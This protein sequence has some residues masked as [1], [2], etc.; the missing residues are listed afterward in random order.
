MVEK[1]HSS[2]PSV[3][4]L[5]TFSLRTLIQ[6]RAFLGEF[7]ARGGL[8]ALQDVIRRSSG[9][10]L[11]YSL[12]S[13]QN[14]LELDEDGGSTG[15]E[16]S[17]VARIV[18]I[19]GTQSSS[20]SFPSFAHSRFSPSTATEPLINISR[21]ATAILRRLASQPPSGSAPYNAESPN[22]STPRSGANDG[23][24]SG[25]AAVY[26]EISQ[27]PR[28]LTVVVERLSSGDVPVT[29]SSL[30]LLN[31][32]LRGATGLGDF[33]LSEE[34]DALDA[35]KTVG[36]RPLSLPML[37]LIT[38]MPFSPSQKLLAGTTGADL[39]TL[40]SLQSALVSSLNALI[41]T[42][43]DTPH[44][45]HFDEIWL[46]SGLEDVDELNRWRRLGFRT[47]SPQFEFDAVGVLG[48]KQLARYATEGQNE[49]AQVCRGCSLFSI[50]S[51]IPRGRVDCC[52]E[53]DLTLSVISHR[54]SPTNSP[55]PKLA[56]APSQPSRIPSSTSS[57]S[58]SPSSSL[59]PPPRPSFRIPTSS[60]SPSSTPSS[61]PSS[62]ECGTTRP[63]RR[64][65][66][67]A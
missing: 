7:I 22:S 13:L 58:T 53:R 31:T 67:T 59:P 39:P 9:N 17:F 60:A 45:N 55:V 8:E 19:I 11:A 35:W 27:Q 33:R 37:P 25:F 3:V 20:R 34:L 26:D 64:S 2:A 14:L 44:Y 48:L 36:V 46:A 6:E 61:F 52:S 41:L 47:E 15:L 29:N 50:S 16:R 57:P 56:A 42:R 66:T 10:T 5:A 28:F 38:L 4:K 18:E 54:P 30:S 21:P 32:L 12:L 24:A 43:V 23:T 49:F 51:A 65:T 63:R 1:L 62:S 40:L